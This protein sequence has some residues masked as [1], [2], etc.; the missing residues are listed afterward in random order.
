MARSRVSRSGST[1]SDLGTLE[2]WAVGE[3]A[4]GER[5]AVARESATAGASGG[6]A[7]GGVGS[8]SLGEVATGAGVSGG[9]GGGVSRLGATAWWTRALAMCVPRV[10]QNV[11]WTDL[12]R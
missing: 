5:I 9:G 6:A 11:R 10:F 12:S 7:T 4:S 1:A 2:T 8:G 3:E